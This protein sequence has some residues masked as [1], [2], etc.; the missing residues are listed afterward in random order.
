M[1]RSLLVAGVSLLLGATAIAAQNLDIIKQRRAAMSAIGAAGLANF[2]MLREEI[3][4]ELDKVQARLKIVQ[5]EGAKFKTLFPDDSKT[6]GETDAAP[7]IWQ[8]K[9]EFDSASDRL[10]GTAKDAA[11][12]IKDEQSFKRVYPTV[13]KSCGGCHDDFNGFAPRLS[14]SLKRLKQ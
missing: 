12:Q 5:D 10:V 4:F 6:G 8:A 1:R 14:D 9:G 13:A 7:R 11:A 2:K 3:P